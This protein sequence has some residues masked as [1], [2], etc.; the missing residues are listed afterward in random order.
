M[1]KSKTSTPQKDITLKIDVEA[2]RLRLGLNKNQ[3]AEAIGISP[4]AYGA[5]SRKPTQI[6]VTTI[7]GLKNLGA[8][9]D[10]IFPEV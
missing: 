7:A 5:L 6:R 4:T 1:S 10:E 8:E 3:M 9:W 2:V